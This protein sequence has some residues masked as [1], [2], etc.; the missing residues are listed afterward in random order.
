M[1]QTK[2]TN[3]LIYAGNTPLA[4]TI[5]IAQTGPMQL[6]VRAGSFTTTGQSRIVDVPEDAAKLV[7]L[8]TL[9]AQGGAEYLPGNR[10]A[11]VWLAD[12]AGALLK[13]QTFT[14]AADAVFNLTSDSVDSKAYQA[15]LG[16]VGGVVDVLMRSRFTQD[17]YSNAPVGWKKIHDI[18]FEFSLPP[19]TTD[20]SGLDI[21][22]L[23]VLPGFPPGTGVEDWLTQTGSV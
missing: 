19:G 13:A 3:G 2:I 22:V 23:A 21:F 20:L 16:H 17:K 5:A 1:I 14:L 9:I 6:T 7:Q 15:E 4:S 18:I 10:Q 11:R 8:Q 12:S